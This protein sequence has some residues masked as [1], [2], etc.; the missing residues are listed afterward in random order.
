VVRQLFIASI[1]SMILSS[2]AFAGTAPIYNKYYRSDKFSFNGRAFENLS[3]DFAHANYNK[4][5]PDQKFLENKTGDEKYRFDWQNEFAAEDRISRWTESTSTGSGNKRVISTSTS[6]F[7]NNDKL[8]ARTHCIS[9]GGDATLHCVT[10]TQRSCI[11]VLEKYD[12]LN[13]AQNSE[14]PLFSKDPVQNEKNMK[15]CQNLLQSYA[16]IAKASHNHIGKVEGYNSVVDGDHKAIAAQANL[17]LGKKQVSVLGLTIDS[18]A[19]L[20]SAKEAHMNDVQ[21]IAKQA[22]ASAQ[23]M[24]SAAGMGLIH[25]LVR[26]CRESLGD[27][28][29]TRIADKV[30]TRNASERL[31]QQQ[32]SESSGATK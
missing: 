3:E 15:S 16:D 27:F 23:F 8:R 14:N 12:S 9:E 1:F 18:A 4:Q 7:Y 17:L 28:D 6:T 13:Q 11:G 25:D 30:P 26:M 22:K 2:L 32:D 20:V 31:R 19:P 5:N 24:G 10:A 29:S 21:D